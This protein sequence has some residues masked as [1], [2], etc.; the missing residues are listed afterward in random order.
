MTSNDYYTYA[1]IR[2]DGTPYYIGKG[3]S[4]RAYSRR[5]V[6]QF[7][8]PSDTKRIILLKQN[9]TEEEAFKHE[10]YMIAV[11]GRKDLG[12]GILHNLTDG[13]EGCSGLRRGPCSE[14]RRKRLSETST[15]KVSITLRNTSTGEI[16]S[17]SSITSCANE[18]GVRKSNLA[19]ILKKHNKGLTNQRDGKP[20]T[21]CKKQWE[22]HNAC[23]RC[24]TRPTCRS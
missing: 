10:C 19:Y 1:W 16:R 23:Q 6:G 24:Q 14:L 22:F 11:Y 20:L 4:D 3:K 13:G 2:I 18:L 12:T 17:W 9:L 5:I 21:I 8:P 15:V 7:K